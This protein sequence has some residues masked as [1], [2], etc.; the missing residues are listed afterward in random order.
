MTVVVISARLRNGNGISLVMLTTAGNQPPPRVT[1]S[2]I[3]KVDLG[4]LSADTIDVP[5]AIVPLIFNYVPLD[6]LGIWIPIRIAAFP[7]NALDF[8]IEV[9]GQSRFDR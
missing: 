8:V 9:I 3:V 2:V 6:I 7:I 4:N 1:I 5:G